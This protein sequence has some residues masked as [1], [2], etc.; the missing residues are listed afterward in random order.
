MEEVNDCYNNQ[1]TSADS[2]ERAVSLKVLLSE[3]RS[4]TNGYSMDVALESA[5]LSLGRC[6]DLVRPAGLA[7]TRKSIPRSDWAKALQ[8]LEAYLELIQGS[9]DPDRPLNPRDWGE[10]TMD[11]VTIGTTTNFK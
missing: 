11:N 2:E 1:N 5:L 3:M 9:C 8:H 4:T 6:L 10:L 7:E